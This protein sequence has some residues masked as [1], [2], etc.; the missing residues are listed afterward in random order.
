MKVNSL[1]LALK[2]FI[3]WLLL[4]FFFFLTGN[5]LFGGG[6]DLS[7]SSLANWDGGHF[8]DIAQQG[9][10]DKVQYAFFPLYPL[11]INFSAGLSNINFLYAGLLVNLITAFGTVYVFIL[12]LNEYA[13][14]SIKTTF[15]F[16]I[17]PTAFFLITA[18][19]EGL[20]LFLTLLTF[21]FAERKKLLLAAFFATLTTLT[22]I[23]GIAVVLSFAA[24]IFFL[25]VPLGK[26]ISVFSIS[27][28][29]LILYCIYLYLQTGNPFY[30]LVSELNWGRTISIPGLNILDSV[31]YIVVAG[32]KPESFTIFFDL[33][34]TIFGLGM[35]IRVVRFLKPALGVYTIAALF[36]PLTTALLL[37]VPRFIL[38]VFPI[39]IVLSKINNR[40][41]NVSYVIISLVFLF[42]Y[43]NF[44]LRNIWVS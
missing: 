17:F 19:S 37:S 5:L 2:L 3:L 8:I 34:F 32:L 21:F 39:F 1:S 30:F 13:Q 41:F 43:F 23:T 6:N 16:L 36:I 40:I 25:K 7:F 26:K 20:F 12:L 31:T 42:L 28:S 18:Y 22:R 29:G 9:Y 4:L 24:Y 15:Y 14:N 10:T 35:G 44:F 27:I 38:V 11:L 33:I